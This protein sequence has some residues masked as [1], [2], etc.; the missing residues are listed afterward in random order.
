MV[1]I[2]SGYQNF[3][4]FFSVTPPTSPY[5][6]IND[7]YCSDIGCN[8]I[9]TIDDCEN[10][11]NFLG[12]SITTSYRKMWLFHESAWNN[13]CWRANHHES[14]NGIYHAIILNSHINSNDNYNSSYA[15]GLCKCD[16]GN[17]FIFWRIEQ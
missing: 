11:A 9:I 6:R 8:T 2:N 12:Y 16:T 10:A 7:G 5:A 1:F 17:P 13:G 14:N 15:E 3:T 4:I